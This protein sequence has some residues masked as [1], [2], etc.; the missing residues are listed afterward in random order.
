MQPIILQSFRSM[1]KF[2]IQIETLK[3]LKSLLNLLRGLLFNF[4]IGL[5]LYLTMND[6]S[7]IKVIFTGIHI[8]HK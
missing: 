8:T 5:F 1:R 3:I 7:S 4:F 6:N 2:K